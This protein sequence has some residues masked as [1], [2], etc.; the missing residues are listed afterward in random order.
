LAAREDFPYRVH[1]DHFV[2]RRVAGDYHGI[3]AAFPDATRD[4][5]LVLNAEMSI[6]TVSSYFASKTK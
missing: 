3:N 5:L 6:T 4:Q 2:S 1:S